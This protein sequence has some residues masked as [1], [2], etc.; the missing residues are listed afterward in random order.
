[1]T[2]HPVIHDILRLW[3]SGLPVSQIARKVSMGR[4]EVSTI[5]SK[6]RGGHDAYRQW[7]IQMRMGS[8]KLLEAINSAKED[9]R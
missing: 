3:D 5:I 8:Q 4:N 1:M 7:C 6:K 2:E 9:R